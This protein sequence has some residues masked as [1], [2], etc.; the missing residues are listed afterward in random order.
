ME[1]LDSVCDSMKDY[2]LKS[3]ATDNEHQAATWQWL[4]P[5]HEQSRP[6]SNDRDSKIDKAHLKQQQRRLQNYCAQMLD[7]YEDQLSAAL[8]K[9]SAAEGKLLCACKV[10]LSQYLS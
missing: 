1:L 8:Q 3:V 5:K 4:H 9:G 7:K 6:P 2:E 10:K